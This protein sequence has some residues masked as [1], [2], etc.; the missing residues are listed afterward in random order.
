MELLLSLSDE[1]GEAQRHQG[2]CLRSHSNWDSGTQVWTQEL[3]SKY[4]L[5]AV[6]V[7]LPGDWWPEGCWRKNT[8]RACVLVSFLVSSFFHLSNFYN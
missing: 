2:T 5:P 6:E 7:Y 1:E 8:N 4:T 3:S